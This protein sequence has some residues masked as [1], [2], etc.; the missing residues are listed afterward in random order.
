[1]GAQMKASYALWPGRRIVAAA[2]MLLPG[3]A[4]VVFFAG[5]N[6]GKRR[7]IATEYWR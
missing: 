6:L 4:I 3:S 7:P 5:R 2:L 1:M